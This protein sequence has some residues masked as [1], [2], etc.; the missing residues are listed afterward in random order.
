MPGKPQ[1]PDT[2][3]FVSSTHVLCL[4]D[5]AASEMFNKT[6]RKK[7]TKEAVCTIAQL[8]KYILMAQQKCLFGRRMVD[9]P[10]FRWKWISNLKLHL[11]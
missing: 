6:A 7:I 8:L 4:F 5:W 3:S 10:Y 1:I 2:C 9:V 11:N